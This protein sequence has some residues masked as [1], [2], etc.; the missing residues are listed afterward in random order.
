RQGHEAL[1][2]TLRAIASMTDSLLDSLP[3]ILEKAEIDALVLD[4]YHFYMELVPIRLGMPYAHLS[5][6]LHFDY[7]G[8]TPL[9]IYDWP[10]ERTSEALT[11]NRKGVARFMEI[12]RRTNPR[13]VQYAKQAGIELNSDGYNTISKLAWITQTP[14]EFDFE[15]S[16]WSSTLHHTGPFLD[17]A[18][19]MKEDFPWEQITGQPIIYASMGTLQNGVA[20]VYHE[21]VTAV[22]KRKDMQLVLSI[23]NQVDRKQIGSLPGNAIVVN[24][25]PQ[26]ELLQRASVCITHAGLN[27]VL[28][29]L[30]NGVPQVAIPVT[31][32]QPGVAARIADK[33]TG[34]VMPLKDLNA[35]R[36]ELLLDEAFANATYRDNA[37]HFQKGLA[38]YSGLSIAAEL[39]EDA[40]GLSKG[41]DNSAKQPSA[42]RLLL[43][44]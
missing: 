22:E 12:L 37:R 38:K 18:G 14:K 34:L 33:K 16:H 8:Y 25:A 29:C 4:T 36:L 20:S 10:H 7:S 28:E 30:L 5:N 15:S 9:C 42:H 6:A 23:G 35:S 1:E 27:T 39:L 31:H 17:P 40:F 21:I 2:F 24:H 11:R 32:D 41:S 19:R 13:A 44:K 3:G 43:T 26:F